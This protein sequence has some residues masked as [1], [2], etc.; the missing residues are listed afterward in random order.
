MQLLPADRAS[1]TRKRG[2]SLMNAITDP[3]ERALDAALAM[4]FPASDPV[5]VWMPEPSEAPASHLRRV[6]PATDL[7]ERP[8]EPVDL[9]PGG[10]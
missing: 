3:L 6:D 4:T 7:S 10:R 1:I 2:L 9:Q 8:T 5:A